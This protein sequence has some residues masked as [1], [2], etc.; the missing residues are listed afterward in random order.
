MGNGFEQ[1]VATTYFIGQKF[2]N[3]MS[4]SIS[5]ENLEK[6]IIEQRE[7]KISCYQ[8][9]DELRKKFNFANNGFEFCA[10]GD[11]LTE[12]AKQFAS[13]PNDVKPKSDLS[14]A[15]TQFITTWAKEN[16]IQFDK[17]ILLGLTYRDADKKNKQALKPYSITHVDFQQSTLPDTFKCLE[18]IWKPQVEAV[19]GPLSPEQYLNLPIK[20]MVN[21]WFPLNECPTENGLAVMDKSSILSSKSLRPFI[22]QVTG[23][24]S[25]NSLSLRPDEKQLWVAQRA[26][27]LGSGVIFSS[28]E[29]PHSAVD[30]K[31]DP[32]I[33]YDRHRKSVEARLLII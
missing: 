12:C 32:G 24:C 14:L 33:K 10:L 20:R 25:V 5:P 6:K 8:N 18:S 28:L 29:V 17:V 31:K 21:L 11:T 22:P 1:K 19:L 16:N 4:L 7:I 15:A 9:V 27:T 30:L 13:F 23:D 26:M 2:E 3:G